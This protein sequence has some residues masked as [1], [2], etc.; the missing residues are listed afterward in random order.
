MT[1]NLWSGDRDRWAEYEQ[2]FEA[3]LAHTPHGEGR[4][5]ALAIRAGLAEIAY[6]LTFV[7]TR[8][9]EIAHG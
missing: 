6:L 1:E 8:L 5:V 3:A 7:E 9:G 4:L 2:Q